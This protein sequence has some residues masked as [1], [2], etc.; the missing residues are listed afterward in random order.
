MVTVAT[1]LDVPIKLTFQGPAMK[2]S[3]LGLGDI[4]VPGMFIGLALRFDHFMHYYRRQKYEPVELTTVTQAEPTDAVVTT[5][6]VQ[7]IVVKAEYVK[8]QGQWGNWFWTRS[9]SATP[10][11]KASAFSKPYFLA[12]ML[13]YFVAMVATLLILLI[14]N[15]AQPALL[16]LVPGVVFAVWMTGAIRGELRE[17]WL[18]TED[19]SLDKTDVVVEVDANGRPLRAIEDTKAEEEKSA[20]DGKGDEAKAGKEQALAEQ[21][22]EEVGNAEKLAARKRVVFS[23]SIVAPETKFESSKDA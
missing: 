21:S 13:G 19:G 14:F 22:Q 6:E 20:K 3:M 4:V 16:Y 2:A 1:K 23:M 11:V 12:A 9:T 10:A 8:P 18:Y 5:K 17:M 15:H 7:R